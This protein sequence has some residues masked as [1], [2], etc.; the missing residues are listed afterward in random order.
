M[1]HSADR[2]CRET[3]VLRCVFDS[4]VPPCLTNVSINRRCAE[5]GEPERSG[6]EA[7]YV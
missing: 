2:C 7:W 1:H 5:K 6:V 3:F 4:D